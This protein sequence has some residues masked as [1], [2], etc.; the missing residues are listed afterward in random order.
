MH[1]PLPT[2]E[3]SHANPGLI[4]VDYGPVLEPL[5]QKLK[6]K[7]LPQYQ[8][9][10]TIGMYRDCQNLLVPHIK[11]V[12]QD[13]SDL[14]LFCLNSMLFLQFLLQHGCRVNYYIVIIHLFDSR[15]QLGF[16]FYFTISILPGFI[17]E[18]FIILDLL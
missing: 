16:E 10:G 1:S 5:P 6:S 3:V 14:V 4:T 7:L 2:T 18:A 13:K 15:I 12:S 11:L 17:K 8:I 9:L